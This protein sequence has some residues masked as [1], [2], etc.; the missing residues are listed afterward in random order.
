MRKKPGIDFDPLSRVKVKD[1]KSCLR[2]LKDM[3][4][5]KMRWKVVIS[6]VLGCIAIACSLS[7]VW[8]SKRLVDVATGL[9]DEPLWRGVT[10]FAVILL[11][12]LVTRIGSSYWNSYMT[13]KCA[14]EMRMDMFS[15]VIRSQWSGKDSFHSGDT[16]NR[17]EEDIRVV[18]DVLC[19]KVP[20]LLVTLI[21]LVASSAY[22]L[23]LA[24]K[25]LWVLLILAIVAVI[26]S[27]M[28]FGVLRKLTAMIRKRE[29]E[30]QQHMQ[31][32][33]QSRVLVLTLIGT[34]RVADRLGWLQKDVEANTIRRLN[35]NAVARGLMNLGF[36][37]GQAAAFLWGIFGIKAGTVT[38]GMMT[39]FLQ[40]VGQ[41]QRPIAEV[42][43]QIP[44]F[45][46]ALTS[47]ERLMDLKALPLEEEGEP[48]MIK[49]APGIKVENLSFTYPD[50][51]GTVIGDL[52]YDF[53]PGTMTVIMGPTGAGK[54]T[55]IRLVLGLLSPQRGTL[56]IYGEDGSTVKAGASSRCNFMYVPQGNSLM[57][58][59]IR[60]N[61][62]LA[63]PEATDSM[64][65]HVLDTAVASFVH[66][67]PDGIDTVCGEDGGGLSEG[68]CQ[69][70]A[71]ARA[72]LQKGG[73]LILDES[74]SAL[75]AV[76]EETL[77]ENLSREYH[78]KRTILFISHREAVSKYADG[79]LVI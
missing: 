48:V 19:G 42:S 36:I 38:Y 54:S 47:V 35:Y 17:L 69:R 3:F 74:T 32:N 29:S 57:S 66:S 46:H 61:L 27:R 65:N 50:G 6:V 73:V 7:Y 18:T 52:S 63:D 55:L 26:G 5:P 70:I 4:T 37:A 53:R 12:Q 44:A 25:L 62:L 79:S 40:L 60:D 9:I 71:I 45:I 34:Q 10:I 75:D 56:T 8:I 51:Y 76:T 31:E 58:G 78:G 72:L 20:D 2:G 22:L 11:V 13:M 21:Q 77:L 30:V 15:H 49:G 43:R 24:P 16:V 67:L 68:Q 28:F 14:N 23:I 59:T 41:V 64:M 33:L 39:A 1:L